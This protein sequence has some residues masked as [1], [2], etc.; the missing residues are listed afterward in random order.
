MDDR[1]YTIIHSPPRVPGDE[2]DDVS[3]AYA[4]GKDREVHAGGDPPRRRMQSTTAPVSLEAGRRQLR[5]IVHSLIHAV[6]ARPGGPPAVHAIRVTLGGGKTEAA[7]QN[8]ILALVELRARG[9]ARPIVMAVPEHKL[10]DEIAKRFRAMASGIPGASELRV[11]IWRG[12]EANDPDHPGQKICRNGETVR[13]AQALLADVENEVCAACPFRHECAYLDQKDQEAD[14]WIVGHPLLFHG[15][16]KA[17]GSEENPIAF[18]VVDESPVKAGFVG[19]EGHGIEIALDSLD[20]MPVPDGDALGDGA[21]LKEQRRLLRLALADEPDGPVRREALAA[22]TFNP[23]TAEE[24][25]RTEWK[26]KVEGGPWQERHANRT[27]KPMVELWRA[28]GRLTAPDGPDRSGCIELTRNKDD[29]RVL[30]IT[31]I[32]SIGPDWRVLTLLIDALLEPDLVRRFWPSVR[33]LPEIEIETPFM[34]VRQ[35]T[36]RAFSKSMLQPFGIPETAKGQKRKDL[37]QEQKRR[38]KNRRKLKACILRMDRNA[39]GPTLV[40]GNKAV[41]EA[42]ALPPHVH[43]AWFNAVAG[44]DTWTDAS[45]DAIRGEDLRTIIVVGRPQPQPIEAERQAAAL[46]GAAV[47]RIKGYYP[48]TPVERLVRVGGEVMAVAGDAERH[49]DQTVELMRRIIAVGEI[50]QAIGRGRGVNRTAAN[51]LDVFV[52]SD[53]VLPIPVDEFIPNEAVMNPTTTEL[54]LA[55]GGIA[56]ASAAD[57]AKA[58]PDLWP[59]AGAARIDFHRDADRAVGPNSVTSPY[60]KYLIGK[61]NA[62]PERR[63]IR[64]TYQRVGP[65]LKRQTALIDTGQITDARAELERRLGPL[66]FFHGEPVGTVELAANCTHARVVAVEPDPAEAAPEPPAAA[67]APQPPPVLRPPPSRPRPPRLGLIEDQWRIRPGDSRPSTSGTGGAAEPSFGLSN[68]DVEARDGRRAIPNPGASGHEPNPTARTCD[69]VPA[70]SVR[71]AAPCRHSSGLWRRVSSIRGVTARA[72]ARRERK[73]T[74]FFLAETTPPKP[75]NPHRT[76]P[77]QDEGHERKGGPGQGQASSFMAK[78]RDRLRGG[79]GGKLVERPY[80]D[81]QIRHRDGFASEFSACAAASALGQDAREHGD[82]WAACGRTARNREGKFHWQSE[83]R[84]ASE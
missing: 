35:T 28:I 36:D 12:R 4:D 77:I 33:V 25:R 38:E 48:D 40:V 54:M 45:G 62:D 72:S 68:R 39:G 57:A 6:V 47:E 56:F 79:R 65:K 83:C 81:A 10:S 74:T 64:V 26:R 32:A 52:L 20:V 59:S 71:P 66:S 70:T 44:R 60:R 43:V 67:H 63:L 50:M 1:R 58:Y 18:L 14:F 37:E 7:L 30:K 17:I 55:E 53:V 61:C 51:P 29:V 76:R 84:T 23:K 13:K 5:E 27:I 11:A 49:P 15:L 80:G 41:I 22:T 2:P 9:D 21:F 3:V 24:C 16:P 82:A 42:M 34:T 31:G 75:P 69:A 78:P 19:L 8:I 73:T 46:T